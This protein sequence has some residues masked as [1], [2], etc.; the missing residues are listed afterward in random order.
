M[1]NRF[2]IENVAIS[3]TDLDDAVA[4][5]LKKTEDRTPGYVCVT[6]VRATYLGNHDSD[7]CRILNNSFL[8][9]PDG[10]P[11]EWFAHLSGVI[12]VKKSS[13]S[14]LFDRI[15]QISEQKGYTHFFYGSTHEIIKRMQENLLR[16]YPNLKI[17]GAVSP[18]FKPVEELASDKI[19]KQINILQ[20][21]FVWIGLGAPKQERFIDLI[22]NRIESSILIGIGLVF[23]YQ[24]GIVK[25]APEWMQKNG[26][27]WLFVWLQQP[28]KALRS[29]IYF[30]YFLKLLIKTYYGHKRKN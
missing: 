1:N 7:Y 25:R 30:I 29:Y 5:I 27:E 14:D 10:K 4:R 15:C 3:I 26:L 16:K 23:D 21:N 8:T 2:K 22:V 11:I 17:V 18:P 9:V 20:P 6:N 24:A 12:K 19:I 28:R 13:G